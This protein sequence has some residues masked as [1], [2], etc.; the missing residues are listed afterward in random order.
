MGCF[1]V[2]PG[3]WL[4]EADL[5]IGRTMPPEVWG[6]TLAGM[7]VGLAMPVVD[8]ERDCD[9][10]SFMFIDDGCGGGGAETGM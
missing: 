8:E 5:G 2:A 1:N 7:G 3:V 6:A 10:G 4:L 9:G